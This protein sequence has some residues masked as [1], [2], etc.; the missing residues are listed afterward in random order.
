MTTA[1][2]GSLAGRR[3][4]VV[5]DEPLVAMLIEDLLRDE[6]VEVVGPASSLA[7]ALE[8]AGDP[9]LDGALL[10]VNLAGE[11]VYPVA[12]ILRAR[13]VPFAFVTGYGR[14]GLDPDFAD[15][16]VMPKPVPLVGF[17]REIVRLLARGP[18]AAAR[19]EVPT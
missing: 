1:P 3:I 18:G 6:G 15:A 14:A 4:L 9:G 5:D 7:Q 17:A 12:E 2:A 19:C 11:F 10:D 16:P 13:D 8:L